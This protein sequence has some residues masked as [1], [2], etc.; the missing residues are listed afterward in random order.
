M[1]GITTVN[2][3][4]ELR[5]LSFKNNFFVLLGLQL[6][7]EPL[8][9][10]E[11]FIEIGIESPFRILSAVIFCGLKAYQERIGNFTYEITE[12]KYNVVEKKIL[13]LAL[14]TEWLD[15]ANENEFDSVWNEF[16]EVTQLPKASEDQIAAYEEQ[17]KKN[18]AQTAIPKSPRK[19]SKK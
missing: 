14:V 7:C 18:L 13:T 6:D 16:S 2:I 8:K 1:R 5:T 4:G 3:G 17:L 11:K 19:L 15:D 9:F 12:T 10:Q